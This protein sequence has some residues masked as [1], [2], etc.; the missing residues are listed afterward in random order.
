[1]FFVF[2]EPFIFV[3]PMKFFF[4]SLFSSEVMFDFVTPWT[5]AH[6]LHF[7]I[8]SFPH[9]PPQEGDWNLWLI[10][11]LTISVCCF[12]QIYKMLDITAGNNIH[13]FVFSFS[14]NYINFVTLL[15]LSVTMEKMRAVWIFCPLSFSI[16]H[17]FWKE[18]LGAGGS[19]FWW[20]GK[21]F[22]KFSN[23]AGPSPSVEPSVWDFC[24]VLCVISVIRFCF[25]SH[26]GETLGFLICEHVF[27]CSLG[28]S[29]SGTSGT[30]VIPTLVSCCHFILSLLSFVISIHIR[31]AHHRPFVSMSV[32]NSWQSLVLCSL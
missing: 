20:P 14:K 10:S 27:S 21:S 31:S 4:L 30:T 12:Y 3:S 32:W 7:I 13:W 15:T 8:M 6:Q 29:V 18:I 23:L 17:N 26:F 16:S 19:F 24:E 22:F 28:F 2:L 25:S 11:C 9:S 5:V 1:M